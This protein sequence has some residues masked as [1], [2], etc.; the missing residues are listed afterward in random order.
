MNEQTYTVDQLTEMDDEAFNRAV[1]EN[2]RANGRQK[3]PFQDPSVAERTYCALLEQL[4]TT[5]AVMKRYAEDPEISA[6][7]FART[8]SFRHHLLGVMEITERRITWRSRNAGPAWRALLNDVL[9][10]IEGGPDDAL[11]DEMQIPFPGRRGT[12][13]ESLTLRQWLEVRRVK[14]PSR[15]P[16][17]DV[18]AA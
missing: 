9:D 14:D 17:K 1:T 15:I 8:V 6:E 16:V 5:D 18:V 4:W 12:K 10:E 2:L 13:E 3:S 11:L 7:H